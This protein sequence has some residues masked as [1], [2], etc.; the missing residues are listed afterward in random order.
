MEAKDLCVL[1]PSYNEARTIG[2]LVREL[3]SNGLT[4]YVVDDGSSDD[5]ASEAE[6]AGA[7]VV[8]HRKNMGKGASMREGFRHIMKRGYRAVVVMDGDGQHEVGDISKFTEK[9]DRSGADIVIGN[10]MGDISSMPGVRVHTNRFM[11]G[12]ISRLAKQPIPDSQSGFRLI[13]TDVLRKIRLEC[14]NYEI[15]S[16]MILEASRAGFRIESVPVSTVYRDEV[17]RINPIVDT[18]RFIAFVVRNAARG[19]GGEGCSR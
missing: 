2:S 6:T 10:R 14:S 13:K 16:E 18:L 12:L 11:S 19:K 3:R 15:E 1:I 4:V 8:R 17:S 5:T 7:V 9:M